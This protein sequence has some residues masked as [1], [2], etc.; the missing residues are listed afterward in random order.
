MRRR[1]GG[2]GAWLPHTSVHEAHQVSEQIPKLPTCQ[3]KVSMTPLFK[4]IRTSTQVLCGFSPK[5]KSIAS[6]VAPCVPFPIS[7]PSTHPE[8]STSQDL[9]FSTST[10]PFT[11]LLHRYISI[12]KIH[13][14]IY[15]VL[16]FISMVSYCPYHLTA[17]FFEII[18]I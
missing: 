14:C 8:G 12:N 17:C 9:P 15:M 10:D 3:A 16:N 7:F 4:D 6:T 11:L 18:G 2:L 13:C 1:F 5:K